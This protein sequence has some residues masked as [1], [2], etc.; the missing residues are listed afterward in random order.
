[1]VVDPFTTYPGWDL[2][3]V[4]EV[5]LDTGD[6]PATVALAGELDEATAGHVRRLLTRLLRD[7]HRQLVVDLSGVEAV[8]EPGLTVL[9][10]GV[11]RVRDRGGH[12]TITDPSPAG[13]PVGRPAPVALR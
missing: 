4:L 7:G 2:D 5:W 1:M 6:S 3:P 9:L 12:V 10:E 8:E 11:E 13:R